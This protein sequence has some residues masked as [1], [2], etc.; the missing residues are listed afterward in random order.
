MPPEHAVANGVDHAVPPPPLDAPQP[1]LPAMDDLP[2][3][4]QADPAT[5]APSATLLESIASEVLTGYV[6]QVTPDLARSWLAANTGNRYKRVN[7]IRSLAADM[8][9]GRWRVTHQGI[10]FSSKGRL[11]DGQHRLEAILASGFPVWL[12]VFTG[13]DDDMFGA[14]DRGARRSVRDE[15]GKDA[16][17]VDPMSFLVSLVHARDR[18][19]AP[20]DVADML[21]VYE[22]DVTA[23]IDASGTAAKTRSAAPIRA[24]LAVRLHK[25]RPA[26]RS[27]LLRQW[28]AFVTLQPGDMDA[29]S[30]A[31]LRRLDSLGDYA[32][33]GVSVSAER[34]A[35]A[36]VAWNPRSRNLSRIQLKSVASTLEDVREAVRQHTGVSD[37]P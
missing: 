29:T 26:D 17:A 15:L 2:E 14:L 4:V 24:A 3:P 6:V 31:L 13:L 32:G 37:A 21:A 11:I 12:T 25:A 19:I 9:A 1:E 36:W 33:R 7:H 35:V 18:N 28:R 27:L 5:N 20:Q 23:I 30:G 10:A 8:T 22:A 34:G 16:R